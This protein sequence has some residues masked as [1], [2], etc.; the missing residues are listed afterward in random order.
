MRDKRR[1]N[2]RK[3]MIILLAVLAV[4]MLA[5]CSVD[6]GNSEE[7][8]MSHN[9]NQDLEALFQT[10]CSAD[11]ALEL[12]R[13]SNIPVFELQGCTSGNETWDTFFQTV[14][15]GTPASVLCAHYYVLDKEHMSAELYEE[16]KDKYPK[17]FFYLVEYDGTEYSV[18]VRESTVEAVDYQESF[19]YL[20]HFTGDAPSS[21]ALYSSYD[22]YVL[23][24]DPTATWEG[25]WAGMVS[26]QLDAGYKH[27]TVYRNYLGWK[28]K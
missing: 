15:N 9:T 7:N 14:N 13:K 23:V 16:E 4:V 25:I 5:S 11:D 26:S 27:F 1:F 24:D 17:L 20:L 8:T 28:G 10:V 18:K 12:A 21:T 3:T 6:K 19:K 2:M 22:N